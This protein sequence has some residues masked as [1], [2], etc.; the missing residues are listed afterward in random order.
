MSDISQFR[1][2]ITETGKSLWKYSGKVFLAIL[3]VILLWMPAF[4]LMSVTSPNPWSV[5]LAIL[6]FFSPIIIVIIFV[7]KWDDYKRRDWL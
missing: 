5:P 2:A 3:A 7:D 1:Y 6:L 4:I